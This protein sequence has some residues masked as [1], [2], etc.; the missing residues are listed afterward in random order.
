LKS[1]LL[2]VTRVSTFREDTLLTNATG[3][4]FVRD[5]RQ[6]RRGTRRALNLNCAWYADILTTLTEETQTD[7][8]KKPISG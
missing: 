7:P 3:F 4:F 2:A 1:L 6:P 8:V 5:D